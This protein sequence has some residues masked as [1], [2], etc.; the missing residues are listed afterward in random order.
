MPEGTIFK[1]F[2]KWGKY[3]I[4]KVLFLDLL[5]AHMKLSG[6]RCAG[7]SQGPVVRAEVGAVRAE[8]AAVR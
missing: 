5:G 6:R 4:C 7:V 8:V 3:R 2:F 1:K